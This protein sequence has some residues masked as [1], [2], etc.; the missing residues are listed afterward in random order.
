[1]IPRSECAT[2]YRPG[3]FTDRMICAGY[4]NGQA[5][6][7]QGDSGGP[8]VCKVNGKY[9]AFLHRF[10]DFELFHTFDI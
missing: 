6:T 4:K 2:Y 7:C 10:K 8:L 5:D 1:M 3:A 9:G